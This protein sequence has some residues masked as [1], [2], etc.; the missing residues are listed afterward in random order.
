MKPCREL[1][2]ALY[3]RAAKVLAPEEAARVEAHLALCAAC[4]EE[5]ARLDEALELVKLRPFT[6]SLFP[7][8]EGGAGRGQD[9]AL[10]TLS[11]WKRRQRRQV[12]A[13]SLGASLLAAAGA[14]SLALAPA[15]YAPRR[16][17]P[18]SA[19]SVRGDLDAPGDPADAA[20]EASAALEAEGEGDPMTVEE[21]ASAALAAADGE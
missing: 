14:A 5:A 8:S 2:S 11:R 16:A 15:L 17:V 10:S 3:D 21:L 6:P 18:V 4:R 20:W 12:V 9:L 19:Q 7:P 13:V 1:E